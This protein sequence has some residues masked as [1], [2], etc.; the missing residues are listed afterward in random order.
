M[1]VKLLL[2]LHLATCFFVGVNPPPVN[3]ISISQEVQL[4]KA[5][6]GREEPIEPNPAPHLLRQNI[7]HEVQRAFRVT[8]PIL[9]TWLV[10]LLMSSTAVVAA[11]CLRLGQLVWQAQACSQEIEGLKQDAISHIRY[12]NGE[13]ETVFK[14]IQEN[15][16]F[17]KEK[18][19]FLDDD[20]A[21]ETDDFSQEESRMERSA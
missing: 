19:A 7:H 14:E 4:F 2:T 9:N 8:A 6:L 17:S 1:P 20:A 11:V 5:D 10:I 12:L 16:E 21:S 18:L 13:A 3:A 15:V